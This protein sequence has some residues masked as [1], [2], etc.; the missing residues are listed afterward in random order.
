MFLAYRDEDLSFFGA[1]RMSGGA[2]GAEKSMYWG[3]SP[4]ISTDLAIARARGDI[5]DELAQYPIFPV[6]VSQALHIRLASS[7]AG[8]WHSLSA[9]INIWTLARYG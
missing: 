4:I 3:F 6:G 7:N 8:S 2:S 9:S 1:A 5:A